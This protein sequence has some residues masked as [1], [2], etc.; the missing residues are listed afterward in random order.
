[1]E[2]FDKI[3]VY[4]NTGAYARE[5]GELEQF[6]ASNLKKIACRCEIERS[7]AANFDGMRLNPQA[8]G[9]VL[10][11]YGAERVL[12][13]LANTVQ[14]LDWDG[15]FLSDNKIWAKTFDIPEDNV[16]GIDRR[17]QYVVDSHPAVLDGFI[18]MMRQAV[19]EREKPSVQAALQKA[20]AFPA[21]AVHPH[22]CKKDA[23]GR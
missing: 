17:G 14:R 22:P 12:H 1:M 18:R 20:P 3:P 8:V 19:L 5:H 21:K 23:L 11:I 16:M 6:R 7:I 9:P 2:Q 10:H 13:V 4:R 15:R